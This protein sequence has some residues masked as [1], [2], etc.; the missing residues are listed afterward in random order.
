MRVGLIFHKD[1]FAPA[2]GIDLVR[3]RA[4]ASGLIAEKIETEIIAPVEREGVIDGGIPVR[5]LAA[6]N[7]SGRYDLVK[8][9]YHDSIRLVKGFQ[10]P[11]VSRI[12]RVVGPT[13]PERDEACRDRLLG[14]QAMIKERATVVALNNEEN[15]ARWQAMYG[16]APPTVL[17]PTGCPANIPESGMNPFPEN[18]RALLFLGS[19]AA[20][21][22][23]E[24][25]NLAARRLEGRARIHLVGLN[26]ARMYG[27]TSGCALD[28]LVADHGQLP[29]TAVWNFIRHAHAGLALATGPHA[30]DN[31][32]SKIFNYLRGGLPVVSEEPILNNDLIRET[33]LG[34][35]FRYGDIDDLISA[36]LQIFE[37]PMSHRKREVMEFMASRHSWDRRVETYVQLFHAILSGRPLT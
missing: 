10:G 27:G 31:D 19:L 12:V 37:N 20:P 18:E 33:G 28:P 13:L 22:M 6:L 8:T 1:P 4:I 5:T 26:K 25:L 9:S 17:V 11:V 34:R 3:L 24:M 15:R 16:D 36:A 21:R 14:S 29:E 7:Q 30:F 23:V 32:M 35:V 2:T